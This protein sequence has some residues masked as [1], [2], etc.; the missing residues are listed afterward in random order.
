MQLGVAL[1][2]GRGGVAAS[3]LTAT[4]TLLGSAP[5]VA[6]AEEEPKLWE[7]DTAL[8]Y[9]SESDG[10]VRDASGSVMVRRNLRGGGLVSFGLTIDSLTGAS[11]SGALRTSGAQTF[12][13]PSGNALYTTPAGDIPL[14][15]SFLDTRI[16][17][18][19]NWRMKPSRW[20]TFEV[21]A[22]A[23]SEY[24]Y[25]H[26][27]ANARY[28]HD[29][30]QRNRTISIGLSVALDSIDPEG[31]APIP[32]AAMLPPGDLSNRLGTDDKTVID[33][34]V[35]YS[36]VF[37]R[38]TVGQFNYSFTRSSGYLNDPYKI[39]SVLDAD[40]GDLVLGEGGFGT[41]LFESR[42][43]SR[44]QHGLYAEV[45][46]ARSGGD[47][48]GGS[49]RFVTDDWGIRSHTLD[50]RYRW[51][52]DQGWYLQPHL[53]YYT[54]S[55]ADFYALY[56]ADNESVPIHASADY[57]LAEFDAFTYGAKI[58]FRPG[59]SGDEW[60]L[61]LEYYT[62]SGVSPPARGPGLPAGD[63]LIPSVDALIVQAGYSF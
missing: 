33:V 36:H 22:S 3:L 44:T 9:Y 24:D 20:S 54:Q 52:V 42:P 48:V 5:H 55:A 39:V 37:G 31:G 56:L 38:R 35:G 53:R 23:S 28:A 12:T 29:F 10:R 30:S 14:D 17:L 62:Q 18:T 57:R 19:A 46:H 6:M 27:G 47:I 8:L 4:C 11:P 45:R 15:P 61:R 40:T 51:F 59:G 60:S 43:D 34:L 58:G 16:A 7:F 1:S 41:Y 49:Y 2:K 50:A 13:S 25:V 26:L 21:G 32:L 63:D